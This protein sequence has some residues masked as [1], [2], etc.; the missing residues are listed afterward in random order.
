MKSL[1]FIIL[2]T[3][4]CITFSLFGQSN[5][6]IEKNERE[7]LD[8]EEKCSEEQND[9]PGFVQEWNFFEPLTEFKHKA[10][11]LGK[12]YVGW[13]GVMVI[14]EK[15]GFDFPKY[16]NQNFSLTIE[17]IN[18]FNKKS[19]R[20]TIENFNQYS[21]GEKDGKIQEFVFSDMGEFYLDTRIKKFIHYDVS[22]IIS[23]KLIIDQKDTYALNL[24]VSPKNNEDNND[25]EK[26]EE[27][28]LS[29]K[30]LR[31]LSDKF[32]LSAPPFRSLGFIETFTPS[33][34][35]GFWWWA[36]NSF[37]YISCDRLRKK[38]RNLFDIKFENK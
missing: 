20:S 38:Q 17:L 7:Y 26:K 18:L 9:I 27:I 8:F 21:L 32:S 2:L 16:A 12:V 1:S 15:I 29:G 4:T 35:G 13:K 19:L 10:L 36:K 22:L 28:V 23:N 25:Q 11:V 34:E 6:T 37:R 24:I 14:V 30:Y 5:E 31:N 33:Q 3:F